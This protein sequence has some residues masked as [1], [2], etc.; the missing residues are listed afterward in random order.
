MV[1]CGISGSAPRSNT[2]AVDQSVP[3]QR[4]RQFEGEFTGH[5]G[6]QLVGSRWT[7]L[8]LRELL[9]GPRR[10]SDLRLDV[11]GISAN[12]LAARLREMTAAGLVRKIRMPAP[13]SIDLYEATQW[14]LDAAPVLRQLNAWASTEL[15][16][17]QRGFMSAASLMLSIETFF[18]PAAGSFE[19]RIGFDFS[20]SNFV[21]ELRDT[22]IFA[23]SAPLVDVDAVF[24][25]NPLELSK[26][27]FGGAPFRDSLVRGNRKRARDFSLMFSKPPWFGGDE[28]LPS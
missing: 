4:A 7:L 12:I 24:V 5:G 13:A 23:R 20:E 1:G 11:R 10:F 2:K 27:F 22:K 9:F 3:L 25:A 6:T 16:A 18:I 15:G 28:P 21:V 19:A 14:A 17:G 8:V 26:I